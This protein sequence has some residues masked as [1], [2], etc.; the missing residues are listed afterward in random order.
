MNALHLLLKVVPNLLHADIVVVGGAS[1]H[2]RLHYFE[3]LKN[4][5]LTHIRG[6]FQMSNH[7]KVI[8][9]GQ[10]PRANGYCEH[11]TGYKYG[12]CA[13]TLLEYES[14]DMYLEEQSAIE[15]NVLLLDNQALFSNQSDKVIW[16]DGNT[17]ALKSYWYCDHFH[18]LINSGLPDI[19]FN[20]L[21]TLIS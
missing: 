15:A 11:T 9:Q 17:T 1:A 2:H 5:L 20:L 13:N 6:I 10:M 8:L 7:S 18:Q 12:T 3:G 16:P 4:K 21:W 19:E 14:T